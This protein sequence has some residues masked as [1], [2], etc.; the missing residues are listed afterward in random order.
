MENLRRIAADKEDETERNI[1]QDRKRMPKTMRQ[2]AKTRVLMFKESLRINSQLDSQ[3]ITRR[4][5]K[6]EEDV[7]RDHYGA[8]MNI[9][10]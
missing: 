2:E 10:I 4:V 3:E 1:G 5:K 7:S 9:C 8:Y 6:F